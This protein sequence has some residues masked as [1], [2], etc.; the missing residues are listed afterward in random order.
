MADNDPVT[1]GELGPF[2]NERQAHCHEV[3]AQ[4]Q[5]NHAL[6]IEQD[7]RAGTVALQTALDKLAIEVTAL[8][9]LLSSKSAWLLPKPILY[10]V[11]FGMIGVGVAGEK[12]FG[13]V[14]KFLGVGP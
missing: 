10:L 7:R 6:R 4:R 11:C 12:V 8:K 1:W 3:L 13:L 5:D 9:E 2:C 14:L